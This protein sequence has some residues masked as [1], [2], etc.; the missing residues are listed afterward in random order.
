MCDTFVALP[1]LTEGDAVILGK[2]AD[3]RVNEAHALVR[4]PHKKHLPGTH[5][6]AT[7]IVIP[8]V[9]ETYDVVLSKSFWTWGGEIGINEHGV[10]IGNEAVFSNVMHDEKMDGLITM[11]LLRLGLERSKTA[12]EAVQVMGEM[13]HQFG[14]G[15]NC[16]LPGNSPWDSSYLISDTKE[17]WILETAGREWAA[18][19]ARTIDSISNAYVIGRDWDLCSLSKDHPDLDWEAA[20]SDPEPLASLGSLIRQQITCNTL[21]GMG[22]DISLRT[23]FD[24]LRSHPNGYHPATAEAHSICMHAG[25]GDER[26]W[27]ATGAMVSQAT[28][29]GIIGWF[30]GTSSTCVSIFKPIFPGVDLPDMGPYPIETFNPQSLW[31]LGELL[32]RRAMADFDNVVP[33]IRADFEALED[34][35]IQEAQTVQKGIHE[36]KKE[37]ME[38]CFQRAVQAT[39]T[40]AERLATRKDLHFKDHAYYDAWKAFNQEAGLANMPEF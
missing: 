28:T 20:F 16:E 22:R 34:E 39:N 15:G 33:E 3:C 17:A 1:P 11:D 38:D 32:H 21:Q 8:Q 27:N 29:D 7:H 6:R 19:K 13:V 4:I 37:F 2:S 35:F 5:V 12:L 23:S 30:T 18:K 9:E 36:Q 31:W 25:P 24:L 14:Q 40:W 26:L 10:A